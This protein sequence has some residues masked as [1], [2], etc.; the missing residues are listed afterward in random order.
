MNPVPNSKLKPTKV[1]EATIAAIKKVNGLSPT[2]ILQGLDIKPV[3]L[4]KDVK[5]SK[6][7]T[8]NNK[9]TAK[10]L[11]NIENFNGTKAGSR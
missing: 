4:P 11:V 10:A 7:V 5:P 8:N 6:T 3:N 9:T 2:T 1:D